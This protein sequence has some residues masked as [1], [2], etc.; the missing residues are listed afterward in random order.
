[1]SNDDEFDSNFPGSENVNS[2]WKFKTPNTRER[3]TLSYVRV[4][5][6]TANTTRNLQCR[7]DYKRS[8]LTQ[9]SSPNS[10]ASLSSYL[11]AHNAYVTQLHATNGMV[12]QY[13]QHVLPQLLQVRSRVQETRD[14]FFFFCA[15]TTEK[16]DG[17]NC[18]FFFSTYERFSYPLGSNN[19]IRFRSNRLV[20]GLRCVVPF[21]TSNTG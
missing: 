12:E 3:H 6:Q 8:F 4:R 21:Y 19:E 13:D 11:D 7:E 20:K 16:P 1:M 14:S 2:F 15:R 18:F 9:L 10:S 5:R 17:L